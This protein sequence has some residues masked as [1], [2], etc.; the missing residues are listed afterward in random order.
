MM[1]AFQAEVANQISALHSEICSKIH[2]EICAEICSG[3]ALLL[4]KRT[5][6]TDFYLLIGVLILES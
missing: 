6:L 4:R 2:S 3:L 1:E 5:Y